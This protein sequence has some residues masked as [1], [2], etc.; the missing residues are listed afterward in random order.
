V[1]SLN[2]KNFNIISGIIIIALS[3]LLF[4]YSAAAVVSILVILAVIMIFIGLTQILN[5]RSDNH[6]K[7]SNLVVKYLIAILE[8]LMGIILIISLITDPIATAIFSIRLLGFVILLIGLSM[9][10]VGSMNYDYRKEYR[11]ILMVFGLL[12]IIFGVLILFIPTIVFNLVAIVVALPL[13]FNGL[14]RL[15]KGILN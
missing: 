3:L 15:L 4:V 9:L 14:S 13:L 1:A 8:L 6:L 5:T 2:P 11:Y 10:Y 7:R 12:T